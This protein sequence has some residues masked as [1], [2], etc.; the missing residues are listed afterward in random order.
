MRRVAD[1]NSAELSFGNMPQGKYGIYVDGKFLRSA[2]VKETNEVISESVGIGGAERDVV[3]LKC[4][5]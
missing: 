4:R 1:L 5:T 3:V 2:V